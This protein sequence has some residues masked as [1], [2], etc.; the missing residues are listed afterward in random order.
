MG[1]PEKQRVNTPLSIWES[2]NQLGTNEQIDMQR[3]WG[4][5]SMAHTREGEHFPRQGRG[6]EKTDEGA[7]GQIEQIVAAKKM[8]YLF[9]FKDSLEVSKQNK[10]RNKEN[11]L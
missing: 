8:T 6:D 9:H 7:Q 10:L 3:E 5:K 4:L 2:L 1:L 11:K